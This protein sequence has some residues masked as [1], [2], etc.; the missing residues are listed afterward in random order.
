MKTN[1]ERSILWSIIE[2]TDF[3]K[4]HKKALSIIIVILFILFLYFYYWYWILNQCVW[5]KYSTSNYLYSNCNDIL[6]VQVNNLF[7]KN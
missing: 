7:N 1:N 4:K 2:D 6:Q 5:D 3:F